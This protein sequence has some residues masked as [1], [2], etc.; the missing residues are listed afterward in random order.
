MLPLLLL[1]WLPWWMILIP[2]IWPISW[3]LLWAADYFQTTIL[4]ELI[5][6][7]WCIACVAMVYLALSAAT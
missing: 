4:W 7:A 2:L 5:A 1:L 3:A 6:Y